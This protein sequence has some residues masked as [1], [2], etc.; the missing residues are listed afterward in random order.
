MIDILDMLLKLGLIASSTFPTCIFFVN[1]C[2]GVECVVGFFFGWACDFNL[3]I[4]QVLLLQLLH[5]RQLLQSLLMYLL[6]ALGA[7]FVSAEYCQRQA[8]LEEEK[9]S[10][11]TVSIVLYQHEWS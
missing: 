5:M 8:S 7:W 4:L 2:G 3:L 10:L 11:V 9:S 6:H 1:L